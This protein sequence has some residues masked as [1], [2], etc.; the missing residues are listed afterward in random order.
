MRNLFL[1]SFFL[2]MGLTTAAQNVEFENTF[3][4]MTIDYA[5]SA[6]QTTD[7]GYIVVGKTDSFGTGTYMIKLDSDG[8]EEWSTTLTDMPGG[9]KPDVQQTTDGGYIVSG[10]NDDGPCILVKTDANGNTLW[11]STLSSIY[12]AGD[13]NTSVVQTPDGGYAITGFDFG[14]SVD[15]FIMKTD[16]T[17]TEEWLQVYE[18]GYSFGMDLSL[19]DDGGFFLVGLDVPTLANIVALK[20]DENGNELWRRIFDDPG[21]GYGYS[22]MQTSDGGYIV[23]GS[24]TV[25]GEGAN[26][27]LC[28]LDADGATVW[29]KYFG[30]DEF[31]EGFCVQQ[32][33]DDGYIITGYTESIGAGMQD[34]YLIRTDANGNE[35]W[36]QTYG[37][38]MSDEG[39]YVGETTDGGCF[40]AGYTRSYGAGDKDFYV[41]K[42]DNIYVG[43][44]KV[45]SSA[46]LLSNYP[47][48]FNYKTTIEFDNQERKPYTLRIIDITGKII[49]TVDDIRDSKV[50]VYRQNLTKGVYIVELR[51]ENIFRGRIIISE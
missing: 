36:S 6:E 51:G 23:C 48:P 49:K 8:N 13:F 9:M 37:G 31:D 11:T 4:G 10:D 29:E 50:D 44:N 15:M 39:L 7:G 45:N 14:M 3:G 19:T 2:W 28:K 40:I 33:T 35:I 32:T 22:G 42:I 12:E 18:F 17:G 41:I 27:W 20:A 43:L 21:D 38:E 30:G 24:N 26:V 46:S 1:L 34:V 16:N 25:E 47:N 5:T